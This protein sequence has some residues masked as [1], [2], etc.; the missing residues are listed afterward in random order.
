MRFD[1]SESDSVPLFFRFRST[2]SI[3]V[4]VSRKRH[5]WNLCFLVVPRRSLFTFICFYDSGES[6]YT[7]I[8]RRAEIPF[9]HASGSGT[10]LIWL[11]RNTVGAVMLQT[12]FEEWR[13]NRKIIRSRHYQ[14][15]CHSYVSDLDYKTLRLLLDVESL[16]HW[17]LYHRLR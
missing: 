14:V 8:K 15:F 17:N 9:P 5:Q 12:M 4:R 3:D 1:R 11:T 16:W 6:I 10:S 13:G 7:E 2:K